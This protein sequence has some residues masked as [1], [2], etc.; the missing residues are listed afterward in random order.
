[1]LKTES[2]TSQSYGALQIDENR[3][4]AEN[5]SLVTK[6]AWQV[7]SFAPD[8]MEIEDLIQVGLVAMVEAA[9]KYVDQGH[10]FSTYLYVRVRGAMIDSLRST[11]NLRRTTVDWQKKVRRCRAQLLQELG[12]EPSDSELARAL[13]MDA[14]DFRKNA[15]RAIAVHVGSLDEIYSDSSSWFVDEEEDQH[16]KLEKSQ[17]AALLSSKLKQLNEREQLVLNCYF[18]E[19]LQLDEIGAI[20]D[21]SAVRICQI[22][23][24]ALEK[25]QAAMTAA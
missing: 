12:H 8:Q 18:V 9:K 22:K 10:S 15:D 4:I 24:R 19:E 1:M 21:V 5:H 3:L 25:L 2:R 13:K 17:M 14:R 11:C 23:K 20:L 6:I 16:E 7:K